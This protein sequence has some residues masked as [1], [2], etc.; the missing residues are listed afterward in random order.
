MNTI[1]VIDF[2][3][4]ALP[5]PIGDMAVAAQTH[6]RELVDA[7]DALAPNWNDAPEWAQWSA[8]HGNGLRYW[9]QV[10]PKYSHGFTGWNHKAKRMSLDDEVELPFG[11]DWRLC[12]W[13]RPEV[14]A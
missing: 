11:L 10:E 4:S 13:Q 9:F 2:V 7:Y 5:D 3:L 12:K 14:A 1:R 6:L 8:V